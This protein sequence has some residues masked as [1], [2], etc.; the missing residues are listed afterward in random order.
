[1]KKYD[2]AR[3]FYKKSLSMN[4]IEYKNSISQKAEAGLSRINK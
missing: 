2:L 3:T 4:P 1:M